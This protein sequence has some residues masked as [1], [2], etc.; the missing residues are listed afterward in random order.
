MSTDTVR[1]L[2]GGVGGLL[3]L[4]GRGVAVLT[5]P[6]PDGDV[7]PPA[8]EALMESGGTDAAARYEELLKDLQRARRHGATDGEDAILEEMDSLW[9]SMSDD[10]QARFGQPEG[11]R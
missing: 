10:E 6:P 3:G 7:A 11:G 9:W 5:P 4:N 8:P 2:Y 1:V